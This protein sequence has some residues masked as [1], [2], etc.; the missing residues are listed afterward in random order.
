M[1]KERQLSAG[2]RFAVI[3]VGVRTLVSTSTC[4]R[5]LVSTSTCAQTLVSTNT[6]AR[7]LVSTSTC[8]VSVNYG[9]TV[10]YLSLRVSLRTDKDQ[11]SMSS[12]SQTSCDVS[13]QCPE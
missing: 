2:I 6:W 8:T 5:T 12:Q 7:T 11:L 1:E 3:T 4:A 9:Q 13:I 10:Y